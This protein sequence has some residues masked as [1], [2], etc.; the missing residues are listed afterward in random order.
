MTPRERWQESAKLWHHYL[1]M[2][3]SLDPEPDLALLPDPA[4][5]DRLRVALDDLEAG[6]IAVP[7]FRFEHLAGGLAIHFRCARPDVAG[8]RIDIM[9]RM[10]GLA[11]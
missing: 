7:P 8:L 5:L 4:N 3:G 11:P 2:G 10:R 6:V 9:T 1:A